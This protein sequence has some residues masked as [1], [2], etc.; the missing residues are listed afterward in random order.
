MTLE[1]ILVE[2]L[3]NIYICREFDVDMTVVFEDE[4]R[5]MRDKV[6]VFVMASPMFK[7]AYSK[8]LYRK[9]VATDSKH[10]AVIERRFFF[11][12]LGK[13]IPTLLFRPPASVITLAWIMDMRHV[14]FTAVCKSNDTI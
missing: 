1:E 14:A 12:R 8:L 5:N 13:H 7:V 6:G 4:P 2:V 10:T 9:I 3:K 11:H